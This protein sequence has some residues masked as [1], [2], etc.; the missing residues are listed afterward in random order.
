MRV[1]RI[2]FEN[3]KVFDLETEEAHLFGGADPFV[4]VLV[5]RVIDGRRDRGPLRKVDGER[6]E[7]VGLTEEDACALAC[8]VLQRGHDTRLCRVGRPAVEAERVS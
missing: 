3:G 2:E 5:F 1:F 7:F 4:R 6:L 8:S